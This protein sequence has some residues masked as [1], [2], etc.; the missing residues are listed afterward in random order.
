MKLPNAS[1]VRVEREKITD[2][3]LNREHPDNGGKADFFIALGFLRNDWETLAMA[4]RR[5]ATRCPIS[6]S[7]ESVHGKKYIVD[8]AIETPVGKTPVVRTVW[9]VDSGET[10]PRLVTAY[11]HEE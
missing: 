3:L 8:G 10:I 7:M 2:Y 5:L 6:Q 1:L 11:P 4:L 9:I